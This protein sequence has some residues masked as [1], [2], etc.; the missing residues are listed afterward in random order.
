MP[1]SNSIN[2]EF[3]LIKV[4]V[5]SDTQ[6][7]NSTKMVIGAAALFIIG[8]FFMSNYAIKKVSNKLYYD[9]KCSN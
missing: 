3:N 4:A 6:E 5:Y 1:F 7:S 9:T 2:C 8:F